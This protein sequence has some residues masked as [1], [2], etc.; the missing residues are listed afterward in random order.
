MDVKTNA[1]M[2]YLDEVLR[3][4]WLECCGHMSSFEVGNTRYVG[5]MSDEFFSLESD[6]RSMSTRVSAAIPPIGGVFGY[7]Y[8]FGS[9][10]HLRLKV[11]AHRLAPSRRDSVRLL[12]RNDAPIWQCNDCRETATSLCANCSYEGDA[13]F[14]DA[15]V[16]GHEC[17][18][19]AMLPVVNSPRMG[20]CGYTGGA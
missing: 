15:H 9:T 6:E 20:V 8:D 1:T 19:E 5:S 10:T 13:F 4:T 7:E 18:E 2:Q 14:C 12:A 3:Y 11:I 16:E 17:G